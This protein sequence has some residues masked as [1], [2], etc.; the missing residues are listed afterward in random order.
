MSRL[1]LI[2]AV[3][4]VGVFARAQNAPIQILDC[5]YPHQ[6]TSRHAIHGNWY[7]Q[8]ALKLLRLQVFVPA[9]AANET[10]GLIKIYGISSGNNVTNTKTLNRVQVIRSGDYL[11][12][13]YSPY[14]PTTQAE[15]FT[16][17]VD[18]QGRTLVRAQGSA[19]TLQLNCR[20]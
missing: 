10:P 15:A 6:P 3:V 5:V 17:L 11:S 18:P 12:I 16:M 4:L 20:R 8:V 2:F 13:S 9:G 1:I 7:G 19:E 14:S